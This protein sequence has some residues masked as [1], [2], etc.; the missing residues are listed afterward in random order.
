[1][2][3][4]TG[5]IETLGNIARAGSWALVVVVLLGS[6]AVS[7]WADTVGHLRHH[8]RRHAVVPNGVAI[9]LSVMAI[10]HGWNFIRDMSTFL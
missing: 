10:V 6:G 8:D 7:A 2:L 5:S 3:S 4:A 9:A 1:M